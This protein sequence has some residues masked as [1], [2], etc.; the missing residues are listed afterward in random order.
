[1]ALSALLAVAAGAVQLAEVVDSEVFNRD[2]SLAVVLDDFVLGGCGA[3]SDD[4]K[5]DVSNILVF[6]VVFSRQQY[7]LTG[8][9]TV[10]LERKRIFTY[11][12]PPDV[13]NGA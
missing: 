7:K 11:R 6:L 1:V 9:I 10:S 12:D 4:Y 2:C 13:L 3:S 8:S 5:L